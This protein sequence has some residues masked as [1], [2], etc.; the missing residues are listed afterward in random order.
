MQ[1]WGIASEERVKF[2][3][4]VLLEQAVAGSVRFVQ[5]W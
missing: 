2:V 1:H 3:K 5:W 4:S